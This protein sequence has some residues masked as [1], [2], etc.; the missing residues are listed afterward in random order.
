MEEQLELEKQDRIRC[1]KGEADWEVRFV[2]RDPE[3]PLVSFYGKRR[4][5]EKEGFLVRRLA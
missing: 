4:R 2:E 5:R 3:N 1:E